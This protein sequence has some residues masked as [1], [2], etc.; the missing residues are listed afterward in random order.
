MFRNSGMWPFLFVSRAASYPIA[1][2]NNKQVHWRC[3]MF[4][5]IKNVVKSASNV[6]AIVKMELSYQAS[7][8]STATQ[9]VTSNLAERSAT[10]REKYMQNLQ[11]RKSGIKK[12]TIVPESE[13][14]ETAVVIN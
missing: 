1:E 13:V 14:P 10:L 6:A 12:P 4:K 8:A 7:K 9:G 11:D 5:N 2:G 3:I